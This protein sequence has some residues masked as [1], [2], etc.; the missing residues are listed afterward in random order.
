MVFSARSDA[1]TRSQFT[2]RKKV[3]VT[4]DGTST[5]TDYQVK[6]TITYEPGMQADFNDI[7]FNTLSV[8]YIDYWIESYTASTTA[9]VW[10]ELPDAITDPGSDT[11]LMYYGNS[12][13][14][15]GGVGANTFIQYHGVATANF[16]DSL[17]VSPTCIFESKARTTGSTSII[18]WGLSNNQDPTIDDCMFVMSHQSGDLRYIQCNNES[19]STNKAESPKFVQNTWY[20]IKIINT[21]SAVTGFVDDNQISTGDITTNLP[22]ENL[23]L[24]MQMHT[25][26]GAQDWSFARKYIA[27][28]PTPSYGTVE[29]Q[30]RIP[31][32][33]G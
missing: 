33:I 16:I 14:S 20:R 15:N 25:S 11:I 26:T 4:T 18:R 32:F 2:R 7:R 19:V 13:L 9:T 24:F 30:R 27:N 6:L 10:V 12:G 8:E 28:E 1:A 23:G 3:T 31:Q 21:G 22:D 29:H 17:N 5:P